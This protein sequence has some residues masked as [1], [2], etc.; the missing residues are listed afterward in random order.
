MEDWVTI[1]NLKKRN[2]DLGTRKIAKLLGVSRSTVKRALVGERY[3]GYQRKRKVNELIEPFGEFIRES[4]LVRKQ[5]VSVIFKNLVSKGFKGS[6]LSL[7]RYI[8]EHL[9]VEREGLGKRAYKPYETLPGEQM[10]YD[11]S[12]YSLCLG[13]Q[14]AKVNVHITELGF[15][16]YVVLSASMGVRQGDVFEALEEA[17]LEFGGVA[18]R[19]QVDNARVFV[20][21][22]AQAHF[23]WNQRFLEF[24]GFYGMQPSRSAPYHPWS[25]GKVERPFAYVEDHFITNNRFES[26][27]DFYNKLKVFQE[28]M[29]RRVHGVTGKAPCELFAKEREHLLELPKDK[30]TGVVQRYIGLREESRRVTQDCLIAFGGNRYSVPYLYVG[31]EVWVRVSRGVYLQ[32]YSQVGKL[33][34][35]HTLRAGRGQVVIDQEHYRGYIRKEDRESAFLAGQKLKER[36]AD[37]KR[38]DQFLSAVK[39]QKRFNAGYH[40]SVIQRI[41]T[42][43]ADEDCLGAMEECFRYSCFSAHFVKGFLMHKAEVVLEAPVIFPNLKGLNLFPKAEL[44]RSLEEYRL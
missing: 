29:N 3:V 40:L 21:N 34:A 43:Y 6:A 24:L 15:S 13:D 33:I 35:T 10:L 30:R 41:F 16:R 25:K 42:D 17:F 32:V 27:A 1:R 23:R 12:E 9:K 2:P 36:F 5:K 7:Y 38:I 31:Q 20:D 11:W 39:A 8:G 4:Y 28:E 22:A 44:K 18:A 26:F 37:Y 14:L 19:L